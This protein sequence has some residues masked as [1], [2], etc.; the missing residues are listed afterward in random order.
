MSPWG[1]KVKTSSDISVALKIYLDFNT[2]PPSINCVVLSH[3]TR[4]N[5][6]INLNIKI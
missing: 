5:I 2:Q 4:F 1:L 3:T 6:Y